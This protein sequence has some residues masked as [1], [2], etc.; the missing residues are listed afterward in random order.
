MKP[1]AGDTF[2]H[3]SYLDPSAWPERHKALMR[4]TRVTNTTV[5]FTYADDPSNKAAWYVDL[6]DWIRD[7]QP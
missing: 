6:D 5:Y 2:I 3:K 1:R 7:Y 4:V